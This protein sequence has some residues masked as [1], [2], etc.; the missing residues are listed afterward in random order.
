MF[1]EKEECGCVRVVLIVLIGRVS[2]VMEAFLRKENGQV[3]QRDRIRSCCV[4][5]CVY[6]NFFCC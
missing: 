4:E 2:M 6:C 3:S 1:G 5:M